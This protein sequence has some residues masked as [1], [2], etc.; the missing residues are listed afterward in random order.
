MKLN[1]Q[2]ISGPNVEII[3]IPRGN[4]E[5]LIFKAQAVTN[6]E[7]FEKRYP[8][9]KPP[10]IHKPGGKTEL[11]YNDPDYKRTLNEYGDIRWSWIVMQSLK[12]TETLEWETVKEDDPNTW[13]KWKREMLDSGFSFMEVSRI[14]RGVM[15]ANCLSE[16]KI[17]EAR[18]RFILSQVLPQKE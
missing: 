8:E 4:G 11:D 15:A 1:G 16:D 5:D 12:A 18:Q 9:P 17:E 10:K 6:L 3:P 14:E 13:R 2:I 7:D